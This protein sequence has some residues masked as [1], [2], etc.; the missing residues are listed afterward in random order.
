LEKVTDRCWSCNSV[1]E[2]LSSTHRVLAP[3]GSVISVLG[4]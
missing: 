2:N 1:D 4:R 3:W